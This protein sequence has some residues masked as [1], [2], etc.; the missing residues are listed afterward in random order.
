VTLECAGNGRLDARPL[1]IGEP[2]G[3]YAVSTA[4]RTGALLHDV[5]EQAHP[6]RDGVDVWFE[7]ADHGADHLKPVLAE[8]DRDDL[9][10]VPTTRPR[11]VHHVHRAHRDDN[12]RDLIHP[13]RESVRY[14]RLRSPRATHRDC[15]TPERTV[16]GERWPSCPTSIASRRAERQEPAERAPAVGSTGAALPHG[17][18]APNEN[19]AA[20]S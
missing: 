11:T 3:A 19:V 2:W 20:T 5:L 12:P 1:P 10:L 9:T 4:R 16:V 14:A 7:G 8:T 6:A 18:A 17:N 15:E 13:G